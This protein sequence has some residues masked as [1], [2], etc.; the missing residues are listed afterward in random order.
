MCFPVFA[1]YIIKNDGYVVGVKYDANMNVI[2]SIAKT[3]DECKV[4]S[5]SACEE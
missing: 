4:F 5:G 3:I 1:K 2:H